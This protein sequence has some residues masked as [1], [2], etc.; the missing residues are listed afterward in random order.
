MKIP[1]IIVATE[2]FFHGFVEVRRGDEFQLY[3]IERDINNATKD[4]AL[5]ENKL[6]Q[7]IDIPLHKISNMKFYKEKKDSF[8]YTKGLRYV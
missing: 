8:G 4:V 7:I 1:S 5:Y 6:E 2:D 3:A